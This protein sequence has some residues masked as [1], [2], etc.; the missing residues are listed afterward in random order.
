MEFHREYY[1][2]MADYCNY[3]ERCTQ[4]VL[5]KLQE[6][7]AKAEWLEPILDKLR[8]ENLLNDNRF[9]HSYA[10]GKFRFKKWGKLKIKYHLKQKQLP[11]AYIIASLA[12]LNQEEYLD[13]LKKMLEKKVNSEKLK[14]NLSDK[15]K[16]YRYA[17]GKGYENDLIQQVIQSLWKD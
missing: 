2:K 13:S 4:E 3:Q 6:L 15:A 1:L 8:N 9:A 5:T 16:L 17:V 11:Q 10:R 7:E 14:N 12:A